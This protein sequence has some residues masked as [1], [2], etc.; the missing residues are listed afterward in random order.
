MFI[1]KS[2]CW[3]GM[4]I[5]SNFSFVLHREKIKMKM[6]GKIALLKQYSHKFHYL[7]INNSSILYNGMLKPALLYD[8]T[9]WKN[10]NNTKLDI[11]HYNVASICS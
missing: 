10:K 5:E 8:I 1:S 2:Y 3:L 7:D 9:L 4:E 6:N 11:I